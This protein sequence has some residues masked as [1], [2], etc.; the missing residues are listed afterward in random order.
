V[1]RDDL[2]SPRSV[3]TNEFLVLESKIQSSFLG[4]NV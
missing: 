2:N 1:W 3:S 4:S